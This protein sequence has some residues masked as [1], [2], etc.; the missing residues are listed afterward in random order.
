MSPSRETRPRVKLADVAQR[1]GVS[2]TTASF[3]LSGR[4]DMRISADTTNRVLHAARELDYRLNLT[5]RSLRTQ[6]S[7][8]IGLIADTIASRPYGGDMIQG[9][10][11]AALT[12]Q[13]RML[14]CETDGA[15]AVENALIEDL[16]GRRVDGFLY[17]TGSHD[18]VTVPPA[19]RGQRVV[20][21]NNVARARVPSVVPDEVEGGAT[22]ARV[23]LEAG[24]REGIHVVGETPAD[25]IPARGRLKGIVDALQ[26]AGT[27]L[28]GQVDCEWSPDSAYDAMSA[29]LARGPRPAAVICLNDRVAF[30]VY[31]A[32][33]DA[34]LRIPDDLSVVSFDDSELA[35]WLRPGLTS[36]A[37]PLFE[38][39]VRAVE[40]LLASDPMPRLQRVQMALRRRGSV[41]P[42]PP[43]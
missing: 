36:V 40:T 12:H 42:P 3:V 26:A 25:L 13:H 24:H 1:A 21:L 30:G 17:A 37:L 20:L 34:G 28:A 35:G 11:T 33:T 9:A 18:A 32:M 8:T 23:L 2:V 14:V 10:L 19:L 22:A 38:M 43:R 31:Q 6:T 16:L 4:T 41:G 29:A 27:R 5:A 15:R 39:G 7:S